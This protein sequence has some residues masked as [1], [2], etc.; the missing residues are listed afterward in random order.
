MEAWLQTSIN[1]LLQSLALPEIGLTA[2]FMVSFVSATLLPLGSEPAVFAYVTVS[3][4]MF[5][6]AVVIATIGN[7]LGGVVSYWMGS[8]AHRAYEVWKENHPQA[9]DDEAQKNA[10]TGRWHQTVQNWLDKLG[11]PALLLSWLPIVGDP[12]CSV[13]GWL[14]LPLGPCMAYMAVG[15]CLRYIIMTTF[16]LWVFPML[17]WGDL[18]VPQS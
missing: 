17:G 18:S 14:R 4:H 1:W 9:N 16:L 2:I 12:L 13:A 15:K 3:P 5:W 7:T 8:A 6:P 11:P 10:R